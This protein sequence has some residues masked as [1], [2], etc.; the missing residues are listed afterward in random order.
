MKVNVFN[1]QC[2]AGTHVVD[3]KGRKGI[4]KKISQDRVQALVL[5]EGGEKEWCQYYM[6]D[7]EKPNQ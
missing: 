7:F 6:L 2:P 1:T 4:V 3:D 5:F